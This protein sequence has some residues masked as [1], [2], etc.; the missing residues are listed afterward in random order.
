VVQAT[1][2]PSVEVKAPAPKPAAPVEVL[3]DPFSAPRPAPAAAN[4]ASAAAAPAASA[5]PLEPPRPAVDLSPLS[6]APDSLVAAPRRRQ[7]MHPMAYAFIAMAASFGGVFAWFLL[8]R[9]P[10]PAPQ[11]VVVQGPTSPQGAAPPPPPSSADA[12]EQ[13]AEPA[14]TLEPVDPQAPRPLAGGPRPPGAAT[15]AP[16]EPAVDAR[17]FGGTVAGPSTAGPGDVPGGAAGSQLSAGEIQGVV[18]QNQPLVKRKCWQPA[19][20]AK[21]KDAPTTA[22]VSA[23]VTIGPSGNVESVSAGGADKD[24]PGLAAC[25]ASRIKGWKFPP[26]GAPTNVNIPFVFAG[27]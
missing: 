6:T 12:V 22:R 4:G 17:G 5:A 20:D 9:S 25:V 3:A 26:S 11:I 23:K 27:Q 18:S 16:S 15:N 1:P 19:L 2:S 10:A 24:Y 13:A 8:T 21:S 14:V 7:G